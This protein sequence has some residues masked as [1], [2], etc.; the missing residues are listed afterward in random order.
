MQYILYCKSLSLLV[1][2]SLLYILSLYGWVHENVSEEECSHP[3]WIKQ[4]V[5]ILILEAGS[6]EPALFLRALMGLKTHCG[7][8]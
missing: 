8:C 7:Y 2:Q 4:D 5:I 3:F 1:A 6:E